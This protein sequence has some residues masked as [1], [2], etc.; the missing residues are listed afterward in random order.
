MRIND[1][2]TAYVDARPTLTWDGLIEKHGRSRDHWRRVL[3]HRG[4]YD[5]IERLDRNSGYV[6]TDYYINRVVKVLE[7]SPDLTWA[8]LEFMFD[9]TKHQLRSA[10]YRA[11]YRDLA[12]GRK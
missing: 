1:E 6:K 7:E 5:L 9:R 2:V 4:R 12:K 10:L 3:Q 11:G 8:E